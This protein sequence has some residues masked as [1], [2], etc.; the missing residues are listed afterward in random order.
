MCRFLPKGAYGYFNDTN[1][2]I[3]TLEDLETTNGDLSEH[4]YGPPLLYSKVSIFESD[5]IEQ[6]HKFLRIT[7]ILNR[8]FNR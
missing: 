2:I 6:I 1:W 3:E 4:H 5:A 8:R 7:N